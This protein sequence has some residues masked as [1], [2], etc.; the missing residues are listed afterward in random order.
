MDI[1]ALLIITVKPCKKKLMTNSTADE[2]HGCQGPQKKDGRNTEGMQCEPANGEDW[3][4]AG[5][6]GDR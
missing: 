5:S 1:C 2:L 6:T 4:N 3:V